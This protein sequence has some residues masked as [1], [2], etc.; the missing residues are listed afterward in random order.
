MGINSSSTAQKNVWYVKLLFTN[1]CIGTSLAFV[2]KYPISSMHSLSSPSNSVSCSSI[3]PPGTPQL[4]LMSLRKRYRNLFVF[5][6]KKKR[7]AEVFFISKYTTH[8]IRSQCCSRPHYTI[9]HMI[10]SIDLL[11]AHNDTVCL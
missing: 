1:F 6:L 9:R 3:L 7:P 11:L 8:S 2:G 10:S 4:Q 5:L